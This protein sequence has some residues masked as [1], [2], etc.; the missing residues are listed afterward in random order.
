MV[1][2]FLHGTHYQDRAV[3]VADH[4]I[5]DA[6]YQSPSHSSQAPASHDDKPGSYVRLSGAEKGSL[7]LLLLWAGR[8]WPA[9]A[10]RRYLTIFKLR[11]RKK[12]KKRRKCSL[13][14]PMS[15][16]RHPD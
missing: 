7:L 3:G 16:I 14:D 9:P 8:L 5:G 13:G 2:T 12:R 1:A 11:L 4:R 10:T 6:A 15:L